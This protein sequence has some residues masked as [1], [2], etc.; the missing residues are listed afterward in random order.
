MLNY[1]WISLIAI[2]IIFAVFKDV[3]DISQ[4]KFRNGKNFSCKIISQKKID[5][6]KSSLNLLVDKDDFNKFYNTNIDSDFICEGEINNNIITIFLDS[7]S[8]KIWSEL[9]LLQKKNNSILGKISYKNSIASIVFDE[10]KFLKIKEVTNEG[11]F[12]TA[13]TAVTIAFGL[14]G[15]MV[16]WLGIMKIAD[17]SELTTKLANFVKPLMIKLF[18]EIPA[19]HPAMG[20]MLMNISANMLGLSN[21]ATPFGLKAM[22]ELNKLNSKVGTATDSMC[23]FLVINTSN[24]QLISATIIAIRA[25]LGSQNPTEIL[26]ASILATTINTICGVIAVKFLAKFYK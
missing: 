1:I 20:A 10:V 21:A 6:K 14:I 13:K 18:P 11:I 4:D 3:Q 17:V 26:G 5:E 22:E 25:S 12:S 23:T 2:G 15:I 8:P 7:L 9:S 16:F 24:V 19:N